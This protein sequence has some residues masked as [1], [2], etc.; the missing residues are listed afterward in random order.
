VRALP[1]ALPPSWAA[2]A[3]RRSLARLPRR[4]AGPRL[5]R[6]RRTQRAPGGIDWFGTLLRCP[7]PTFA[8]LRRR[9]RPSAGE[10]LWIIAIDCSASMLQSGAL[11]LAKGLAGSLAARASQRK[12]RLA[13]VSFAGEAVRL[14]LGSRGLERAIAQLRA[15]GGTPLRRA[16]LESLALCRQRDYC[17]SH[18]EKR[19]LLLTDGRTREAVGDLR[20]RCRSLQPCVLDCERGALRLGRARGLAAAL[21]ADYLHV[22]TFA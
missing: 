11:A 5:V 15:G 1:V 19:L 2:W 17:G 7:R 9:L 10:R 18:I 21:D 20:A 12:E 16:L 13:L 3:E 22:E 14:Q 4:T 6:R 8:D